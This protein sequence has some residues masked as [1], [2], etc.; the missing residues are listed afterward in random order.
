MVERLQGHRRKRD[1]AAYV[2]GAGSFTDLVTRVEDVQRIAASEN[3]LLQQVTSAEREIAS[4]Q[5]ALK[6]EE[7]DAA[8]LVA[9]TGSRRR[10]RGLV[11]S[12][13]R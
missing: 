8:K 5:A 10:R 12:Q 13:R 4:R 9:R 7:C 1:A 3:D 2:L 6:S 11:S